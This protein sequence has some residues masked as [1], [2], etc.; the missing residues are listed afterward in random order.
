MK[1]AGSPDLAL[2]IFGSSPEHLLALMRAAWPVAVGPALARRTE[3]VALDGAVLRI[4]VPDATWQR[5]LLRMRGD[6]LARL[7]EIA[8]AAAPRT[9][10]FVEGPVAATP[11][12][13]AAPAR[14]DTAPPAELVVAAQSIQDPVLRERFLASA[15]RYLAR[16]ASS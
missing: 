15:G 9:L 2:R 7:R 8:G 10:G 4:R 3:V 11:V 5:G 6:L 16:F 14:P 12:P 13:T 1:P